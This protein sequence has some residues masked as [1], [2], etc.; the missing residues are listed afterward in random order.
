MTPRVDVKAV[1]AGATALDVGDLTRLSGL[2]QF[3]VYD[4]TIDNVVGTVHLKAVLRVPA[5]RRSTATVLD[6]MTEPILVPE[7]ISAD[8]LLD[9]LREHDTLAVVLD[10]YGDT[11]GIVTLEDIV[12]EVIGSVSDEH[13]VDDRERLVELDPSDDGRARWQADGLTRTDQLEDLGL[14]AIDGPYETLAG[15]IADRLDRIPIPGDRIE[16]SGWTARRRRGRSPRRRSCR[17]HRSPPV[18]RRPSRRR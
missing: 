13:D 14:P 15:L 7:T 4:G 10:E 3:P 2:S 6:L 17:D 11:V 9:R 16:I 18:R 5:D 8:R 12:E 1:E